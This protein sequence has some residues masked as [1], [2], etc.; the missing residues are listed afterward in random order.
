MQHAMAAR[1]ALTLI[2]AAATALIGAGLCAAAM[3][4]P[5]PTPVVPLVVVISVSCPI[6]VG[7]EVPGAIASLR[8][9][10]ERGKALAALRRSLAQLPET[11]HP[12]GL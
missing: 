3:V 9:E 12:L 6:F 10:K 7:W 2:A 4:A 8:A 5:A 1:A 11:E